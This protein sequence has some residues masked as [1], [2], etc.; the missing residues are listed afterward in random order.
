[1][2][3]IKAVYTYE[4]QLSDG[5]TIYIVGSGARGYAACKCPDSAPFTM[6]YSSRRWALEAAENICCQPPSRYI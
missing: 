6:T 5:T 3:R 1:M 2:K 4:A